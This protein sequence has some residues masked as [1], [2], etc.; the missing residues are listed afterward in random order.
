MAVMVSAW[1]WAK[2]Y[3]KKSYKTVNALDVT[4]I[5]VSIYYLHM[6]TIG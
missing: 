3:F 6:K 4:V 2:K 1:P 5:I